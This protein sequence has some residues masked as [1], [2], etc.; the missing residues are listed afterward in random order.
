MHLEYLLFSSSRRKKNLVIFN[1]FF[2][3]SAKMVFIWKCMQN[4]WN[5]ICFFGTEKMM[6]KMFHFQSSA[7]NFDPGNASN[8]WDFKWFRIFLFYN[9]SS[10]SSIKS[11]VSRRREC[12]W[13]IMYL[14]LFGIWTRNGNNRRQQKSKTRLFYLNR[15]RSKSLRKSMIFHH[16]H[17]VDCR[18][19]K[20]Q[21]KLDFNNNNNSDWW[22]WAAC[23]S[24]QS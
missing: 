7:D 16:F 15:V 23:L 20:T 11:V 6:W 5:F 19:I 17:F 2:G 21:F 13:H 24:H 12:S 18:Q 10:L 1:L 4:K 8:I 9:A 22:Q 14:F 3:F